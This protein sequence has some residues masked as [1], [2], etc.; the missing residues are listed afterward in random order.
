VKRLALIA[1]LAT[2]T[3]LAGAAMA[4]PFEDPPQTLKRVLSLLQDADRASGAARAEVVRSARVLLEQ[5]P[6]LRAQTWL[7][8]PL[9]G[10]TPS[11]TEAMAR[12][13][14][15]LAVLDTTVQRGGN[16]AAASAAL[17]GILAGPPF[18]ELDWVSKLPEWLQPVARPLADL[19]K[20]AQDLIDRAGQA[21]RDQIFRIIGWV[22]RSPLSIA[23]AFVTVLATLALYRLAFRAAIAGQGESIPPHAEI[24]LTAGQ[25]LVLAQ[26]HAGAGRYRQACHYLLVS[27][28]LWV[29]EHG[30]IEFDPSATN[31]EHLRRPALEP[32]L[33]VALSPLVE[34]FDRLWYGDL[35]AGD[36]DYRDMLALAARVRELV[37]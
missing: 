10:D 25:A 34:R 29:D 28:F 31:R 37:A 2:S 9:A 35:P 15:A 17:D 21:L 13:A 16:P 32:A 12:V 14:A 8:E 23:L 26:E 20:L 3:L 6:A 11:V 4:T 27:T 7:R 24:R 5:D 33:A 19:M 30:G 18:V 22:A 1:A 36:G